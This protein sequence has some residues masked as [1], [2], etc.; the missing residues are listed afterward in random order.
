MAKSGIW[1][2]RFGRAVG[3]G[4]SDSE[5]IR[6][7]GAHGMMQRLVD[8]PGAWYA[9]L[10]ETPLRPYQLEV[11]RAAERLVD[12]CRAGRCGSETAQ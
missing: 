1:Q 10:Y 11:A 7:M 3:D 2:V 6:Q 8:D 4:V 5:A 9:A 12:D